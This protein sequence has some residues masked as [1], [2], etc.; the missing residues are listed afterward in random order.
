MKRIIFIWFLLGVSVCVAR[1]Q[2][3]PSHT[4]RV[5]AIPSHAQ[6]NRASSWITFLTAPSGSPIRSLGSDHGELNL[7]SFSYF[8]RTDGNDAD[9]LRQKDSSIVS[10]RFGLRIDLPNGHGAGAATVSAFLLSSDPLVSVWV[11]GVRLSTRPVI[12]G[13]QVSYGAITEHVL[14]IAVPI[15]MP[16]AQLLDSIGVIVTPD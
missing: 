9:I 3:P 6:S 10:T 1:G 13:R 16:A 5:K 8:P 11:D 14:K 7:G 4:L 12:I 15:S 2:R